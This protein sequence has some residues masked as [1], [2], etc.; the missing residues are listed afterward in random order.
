MKHVY[1]IEKLMSYIIFH[2]NER[3]M[4]NEIALIIKR[5]LF[6]ENYLNHIFPKNF[7]QSGFLIFFVIPTDPKFLEKL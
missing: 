3:M 1:I 6:R 2:L 4:N 5:Q 7:F